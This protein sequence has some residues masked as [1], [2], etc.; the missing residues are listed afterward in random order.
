M[1]LS[2]LYCLWVCNRQLS[3]EVFLCPGHIGLKYFQV[4]TIVLLAQFNSLFVIY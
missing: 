3:L 4:L 2:T 1:Q